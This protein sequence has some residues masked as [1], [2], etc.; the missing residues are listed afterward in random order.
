M[1][2]QKTAWPFAALSLLILAVALAAPAA[3]QP[4]SREPIFGVRAGAYTD[5]GKPFVGAEALF[6]L[7]PGWWLDPNVEAVFVD[8]GHLVTLNLD[9]HY[10]F[11]VQRPYYLWAGAGPAII[12]RDI[13]REG[14]DNRLG[15][16]LLGGLG[17][18]AG[19]VMPY[20]QLKALLSNHSEAVIAF[21]LRF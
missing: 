2:G 14:R 1:P 4:S 16:N 6:R 3:A 18:R 12:F 9:A 8:H 7:T 17:W 21:G 10:D 15:V 20:V 11:A 5:T 13:D 19:A